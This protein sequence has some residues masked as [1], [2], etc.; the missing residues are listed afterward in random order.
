M[1]VS[2]DKEIE[3]A[4][5]LSQLDMPLHPEL[6][7]T[8]PTK[9][10]EDDDEAKSLSLAWALME[11]DVKMESR[12]LYD[13]T[14]CESPYFPEKTSSPSDRQANT[15][16]MTDVQEPGINWSGDEE[17]VRLLGGGQGGE[18]LGAD[19]TDDQYLMKQNTIHWPDWDD[20]VEK[21]KEPE[22]LDSVYQTAFPARRNK[23]SLSSDDD[24]SI[25]SNTKK[26]FDEGLYAGEVCQGKDKSAYEDDGLLEHVDSFID[27]SRRRMFEN[28]HR[29]AVYW[30]E[31]TDKRCVR[32]K[33]YEGEQPV[34][35]VQQEFRQCMS[36]PCPTKFPERDS[37]KQYEMATHLSEEELTEI[38][39]AL[40][41]SITT[42]NAFV[43]TFELVAI[44]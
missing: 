25:R 20:T 13:K 10:E 41:V 35:P 26:N 43:V 4:L 32:L 42:H 6:T 33:S 3:F 21:L 16:Y 37:M 39:I 28:R 9:E 36:D 11:E 8:A 17:C 12:A 24:G 19:N 2:Y 29:G 38:A 40:S 15:N 5:Y 18:M 44:S 27:D 30:E 23:G 14:Q 7:A 34:V 1:K 31:P 22:I